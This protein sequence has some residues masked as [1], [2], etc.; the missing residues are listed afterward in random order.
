MQQSDNVRYWVDYWNASAQE[1]GTV[2]DDDAIAAIWNRRSGRFIRDMDGEK[3][4]KRVAD[5]FAI[6]DEAGF[7]PRGTKVLDIG[8]GPGTLSLPLARAG[9][10]V[11]SLDVSKGMLDRLAETAREEGL[12]ITPVEC[13]WWTAEID[14]L[15]FRNAFDLVIASMT[16]SIRDVA[17]FDRMVTCSK[18]YCYYSGHFIRR[19]KEGAHQEICRKI[20]GEEPRGNAPGLGMLYPFMYLYTLGYRPIVKFSRQSGSRDQD[21]TVAAERAI[22]FLAGN[23]EFSDDVKEKIREYYRNAATP[24]GTYRSEF[25]TFSGTMVWTVNGR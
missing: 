17:T 4:Q 24:D 5:M 2:T 15:G 16:P 14:A 21:W 11:T 23:R 12:K 7:S 18:E 8:C 19:E 1:I 20:L 6:L 25:E 22:D 3:R 13:S 9:A 10:D